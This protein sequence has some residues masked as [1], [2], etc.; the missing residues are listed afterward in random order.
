MADSFAFLQNKQLNP[1]LCLQAQLSSRRGLLRRNHFLPDMLQVLTKL[2][3]VGVVCLQH[4]QEVSLQVIHQRNHLVDFGLLQMRLL[5][6]NPVVQ[7]SL[8]LQFGTCDVLLCYPTPSDNL[9]SQ[10]NYSPGDNEAA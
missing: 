6:E 7:E 5:K 8:G 1:L 3:V 9:V 4:V 2:L 10:I